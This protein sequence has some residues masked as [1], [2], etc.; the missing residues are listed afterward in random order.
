VIDLGIP[1]LGE[2]QVLD[3]VA[4]GVAARERVLVLSGNAHFFNLCR[5]HPWLRQ[6]AIQR[7]TGI[8]V[9]GAG[10]RLA[11]R[12]AGLPCPARCTWADFAWTFGQFCAVHHF[13]P[14]LLG[15]APGVA[16][17]AAREWR[18]RTPGLEFAGC[19][20]GYFD[21]SRGGTENE[22]LLAAIA[23]TRPDVL[24]V[25]CGMPLQE[26]W[27]DD[28]WPR[29]DVP[30]I[31]TAGAAFDYVSGRLRRPPAWMRAAGLEWLGRWAVE[32]RRLTRRYL[33]GVPTFLAHASAEAVRW[34][35]RRG[36]SAGPGDER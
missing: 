13:R 12:L 32:P 16:D 27:I 34:R 1:L 30:A 6:F 23:A 18:E 29:L 10:V 9:D 17:L 5:K 3:V 8:R 25:G 19:H 33:V 36:R 26:R 21:M 22:S 31:L 28:N 24:I 14:F 35:M 2:S 11:R 4:R 7:A 20:H 15:S